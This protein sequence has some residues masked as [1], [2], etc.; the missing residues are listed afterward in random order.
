MNTL[1]YKSPTFLTKINVKRNICRKRC[2]VNAVE[3]D[4]DIYRDTPLR[5]MGYSNEVGEAFSPLL[6]QWGVPASYAVATAYVMMDTLD[7]TKKKYEETQDV[8][9]ST[10]EFVETFTW[11]MLASV[12]WPG[13]FI[14]FVV[15]LCP[16]EVENLPTIIGLMCIPFI[17]KPIDDTID[18]IME[19]SVSKL[20]HDEMNGVDYAK[21]FSLIST[22][23]ILPYRLYN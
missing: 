4:T 22:S 13:S 15:S 16:K 8:S 7:K 19:N 14:H 6:P 11:Q 20:L 2:I 23:L 18:Y 12:L 5:Y 17:V 1:I 3:S 10:K 21:A 9:E